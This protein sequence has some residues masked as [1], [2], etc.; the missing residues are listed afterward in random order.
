MKKIVMGVLFSFIVLLAVAVAI[1]LFVDPNQYKQEI[2]ALVKE[3]TGRDVT[4]NG[5]MALS[6]FPWAGVSLE[7]VTLGDVPGFG[8]EPLARVAR[9]EVR[10][11][12]MPLL[13]K[14]LEADRIAVKGL[15][16][17]LVRDAKGRGNWESASG[18]EKPPVATQ[19]PKAGAA[20]DAKGA[21][22]SGPSTP[23]TGGGDASAPATG[24]GGGLKS[25][26][27]GGVEILDAQVT[28]N[29][30]VSGAQ[31][32]FKGL[33]LTTGV[34]TPG[35]PV[36]VEL[37]TDVERVKPATKAHLAWAATVVTGG[38]GGRILLQKSRLGLK[39]QAAEGMPVG[40]M[41]MQLAAEIEAALDG[42]AIKLT[43]MD[44]TLKAE[45]GASPLARSESRLRGGV[46]LSGSRVAVTGLTWNLKGEGKPGGT[47]GQVDVA[48]KGDIE[49]RRDT[50][51][52]KLPGMDL[53]VKAV[54]GTL[55][56][57][58]ASLHMTANGEMDLPGQSLRLAGCKLEGWEQIKAEGSL[59][60]S[61]RG[62]HPVAAGEWTIQ[63][64]NPRALWVQMG[65]K[66]LTLTDDKALIALQIKGA[67]SAD[68]QR[69]EVSR[70]EAKL[71]NTLLR[72]GFSWPYD[73]VST[74]RF[75]LDGDVLDLD[76]YLSPRGSGGEAAAGA[77]PATAA[78]V[79]P[80]QGAAQTG[81]AAGSVPAVAVSGDA[82]GELPVALLRRL[83]LEG[84]LKLATLKVRGGR[85]QEVQAVVKGKEGL[86]RLE[87]A[88]LKLYS[89][90]ARL[91]A[92]LDVRGETPKMAW[93]QNLQGVQLE[94][95][96]KEW[97]GE[98]SLAGTGNLTL[99]VTSAGK[100]SQEIKQGLNGRLGFVVLDGA[101]LK[102][103]LTYAIRHAYAGYAAAKGRSLNVGQDTGRTPFKNLQGTAEIRNGVLES[104][105][106]QATSPAFQM[107]GGGQ[108]DLPRHQLDLT[109]RVNLLVALDDV[110][111]QSLKDLKGLAIP[112]RIHGDLSRP[113]TTVD[114]AGLI[115]E[116]LKTKA[117]EKV[118]EKL[119]GKLQE[120]LGGKLQE[121][122]GGSGSPLEEGLKKM[123]PFGR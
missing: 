4:V 32:T 48:Y 87:P 21:A 61:K 79:V 70:M 74:V 50:L 13:S 69:L 43:G 59:H 92:T 97:A 98:E 24:E 86:L 29:N 107:T 88:T 22:R 82:G 71:D 62:G 5:S 3:K 95:L 122:L 119:G 78:A 19:A 91:D 35:Q 111:S 6:L 116:A 93:K 9:L 121:K 63:P 36:A 51:V 68:H 103:D 112:V 117:M 31:Y 17:K 80:V 85:F 10:A 114:L 105:D 47:F 113:Q 67:F 89:G 106:L 55:P 65:Q 66:A 100:R 77:S 38:E 18:A 33:K 99:D 49:G 52:F 41:D 102:K 75:D 7:D 84:R 23:V 54:G 94:P 72:G 57:A 15:Q 123:L 11:R 101:Y 46:E 26:T 110:E 40:T 73:G 64:F 42:S 39:V 115:E 28:W 44:A 81:E 20:T 90:S 118:Q 27:L 108:V 56:A 12:L 96:L 45:G 16:L 14:R 83:D 109:T 8:S 34:V 30:A 60:L 53:V 76:R 1:P 37:E 2:A 58:G 104:K 25:I 120:K